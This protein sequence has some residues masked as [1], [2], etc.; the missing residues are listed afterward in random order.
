VTAAA[1]ANSTDITFTVPQLDLSFTSKN[2][3]DRGDATDQFAA[4]AQAK[5]RPPT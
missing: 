5:S 3:L 1:P 4:Y 2:A